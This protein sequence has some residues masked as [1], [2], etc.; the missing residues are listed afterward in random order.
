MGLFISS[1]RRQ[2]T[3]FTPFLRARIVLIGNGR[4]TSTRLPLDPQ[5]GGQYLG[6]AR[7]HYPPMSFSRRV[8]TSS[9]A[10][11]SVLLDDPSFSESA[12]SSDPQQHFVLLA[13]S[14]EAPLRCEIVI[15]SR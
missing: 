14:P 5:H 3:Y 2:H 12:A 9:I 13:L 6:Q 8:S 4:Y 10:H 11:P 1:T 7:L 15:L